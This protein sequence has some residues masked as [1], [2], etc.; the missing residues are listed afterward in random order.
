LRRVVAIGEQ[1]HE[2]PRRR[3]E[4]ADENCET[5]YDARA[6]VAPCEHDPHADHDQREITS[7]EMRR[8]CEREH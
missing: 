3:D 4:T 6:N 5:A 1:R 2:H 7:D 8:D